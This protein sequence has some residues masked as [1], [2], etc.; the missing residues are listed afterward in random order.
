MIPLRNQN[1]FRL[2]VR[3][4]QGLVKRSR[5]RWVYQHVAVRIQDLKRGLVIAHTIKR[6]GVSRE[7]KSAHVVDSTHR[8]YSLDEVGRK[9]VGSQVKRV[10]C[11]EGNQVASG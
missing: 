11:Q 2:R 7:P 8:Y 1:Q 3:L 5:L 9:P 6:R 4:D 10:R